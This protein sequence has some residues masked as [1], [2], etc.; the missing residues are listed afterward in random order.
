[1]KKLWLCFLLLLFLASPLAL[2]KQKVKCRVEKIAEHELLVTFSWH[3]TVLSDNQRDACDLK[4]S[5]QDDRGHELYSV[6]EILKLKT[7]RNTFNGYE[8]CSKQ[9]WRRITKYITTLDCV[10]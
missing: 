2:A 8:I 6:Y 7:G 3:V 5:F 9:T 1:M 4:I 10:F